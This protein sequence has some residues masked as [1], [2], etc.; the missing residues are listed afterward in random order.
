MDMHS[1]YVIFDLPLWSG[2]ALCTDKAASDSF[3]LN[4]INVYGLNSLPAGEKL[5]RLFMILCKQIGPDLDPN[6]LT[7]CY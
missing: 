3:I 6:R 7:L 2:Q 1:V 4:I 5:C